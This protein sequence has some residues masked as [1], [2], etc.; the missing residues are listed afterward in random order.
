[1]SMLTIVNM[2]LETNLKISNSRNGYNK[3]K[4]QRNGYNKNKVT[5]WQFYVS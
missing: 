3:N 2:A 5:T 4:L 1:M